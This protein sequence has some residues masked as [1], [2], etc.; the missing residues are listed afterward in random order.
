MKRVNRI[1]ISIIVFLTI[2]II[3]LVVLLV[4]T[5]TNV[6]E[7]PYAKEESV[8]K[9][10]NERV[11][12]FLSTT[13]SLSGE[14]YYN[15]LETSNKTD[16]EMFNIVLLYL[17]ANNLYTK[18]NNEY[19]FNQSDIIKYARKY[20]MKDNFDYI[21]QNTNIRYDS[22]NKTFITAIPFETLYRKAILLKSIEI[23]EKS[24]TT[25]HVIYELEGSYLDDYSV[26]SN[27]YNITVDTTDYKIINITKIR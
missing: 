8:D 24:E 15:I 21:S 26:I 22:T 7:K 9:I 18:E 5:L 12:E 25:A 1:L 16:E 6:K 11:I 20:M 14:N 3:G 4:L 19:V 2:V 10:T 27:K 23:Y 13:T 17:Y